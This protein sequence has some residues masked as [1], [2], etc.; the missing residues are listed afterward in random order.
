MS[1]IKVSQPTAMRISKLMAD[2]HYWMAKE[3]IDRLGEEEGKK[4]VANAIKNM[5][6]SRIEAMHKD[7]RENGL[8]PKGKA[9]YGKMKDFPTPDWHRDENGVVTYCPMAETW[10]TYGEEGLKIGALYCQI[11]YPLYAGFGLKLDRPECL[12]NG[13]KCCRFLW[14]E[15]E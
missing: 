2:M 1:D 11:D 9:V 6:A 15:D 8:E 12:T 14:K 3:M 5:A 4:A 7:C 10:A 13:D